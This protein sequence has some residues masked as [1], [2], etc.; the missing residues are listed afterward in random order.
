MFIFRLMNPNLIQFTFG[1]NLPLFALNDYIWFDSAI[2]LFL[3]FFVGLFSFVLLFLFRLKRKRLALEDQ[4]KVAQY[5]I[6]GF[7]SSILFEESLSEQEFNRKVEKFKK[8]IPFKKR[9]CKELLIENIIDLDK[10]LKGNQKE[11]LVKA[12]LQFGLFTYMKSLLETGRWYYI[13]KALYYWRELGYAPSSKA[14]YPFVKHKNM[15]IRTAA[16]LAYISL[17][18]EDPLKILEDYADFISPIDELKLIDIIQRKKI[19]KPAQLGQWLDFNIPTHVGFVLKLVA[20]YNALEYKDKV[21]E[22]LENENEHIRKSALNVVKKLYISDAESYLIKMYQQES[23]E[24][25]IFILDTLSEIGSTEAE[26]FLYEVVNSQ[27]RSEILLAAME[28][29]KRLDSEYF[30]KEYAQQSTLAAVKKHVLDPH[31]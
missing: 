15:Q 24:T 6:Y 22:L 18:E 17:S 26:N 19:K 14:I 3:L 13:S 5:K 30:Q 12:Y 31:I 7:F 8:K 2:D 21:L 16:L 29:L 10:N 9:W 25:K 28:G 4:E 27:N 1:F 20:H 11:I 23:E